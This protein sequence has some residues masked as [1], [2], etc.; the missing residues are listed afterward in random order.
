MKRPLA[1]I[2][3]EDLWD[4]VSLLLTDLVME[5]KL[6][7]SEAI[8]I[9]HFLGIPAR[10]GAKSV[11]LFVEGENDARAHLTLIYRDEEGLPL[12]EL[13]QFMIHEDTRAHNL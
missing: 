10:Q 12:D 6:T 8:Y 7:K 2:N 3:L 9:S 1:M 13:I 11:L 5:D 4:K